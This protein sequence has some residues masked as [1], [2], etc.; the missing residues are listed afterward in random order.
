[1]RTRSIA[2]DG[3]LGCWLTLVVLLLSWGVMAAGGPDVGTGGSA[4]PPAVGRDGRLLRLEGAWPV[5]QDWT[6][7]SDGAG[8]YPPALELREPFESPTGAGFTATYEFAAPAA[9]SYTLWLVGTPP[10]EDWV[11]PL[12]LTLNGQKL[13]FASYR[14]CGDGPFSWV[15]LTDVELVRGDNLLSAQVI[16]RR[17]FPDNE[18]CFYLDEL[19]FAPP[20][21]TPPVSQPP[22]LPP[23]LN[24]PQRTEL[25][26][27]IDLA[28]KIRP[29]PPVPCSLAQGAGFSAWPKSFLTA[30]TPE[31][32]ALHPRYVRK[33]NF[34]PACTKTATGWTYDFTECDRVV[35][36]IL[37]WGAT[38]ILCLEL[39]GPAAT[40]VINDQVNR[41]GLEAYGYELARHLR[42]TFAGKV[43]QWEFLNE[44]DQR[45]F[46]KRHYVAMFK[47]I[48][49][50][51][52]RGDPQAQVGGPATVGPDGV[53][54]FAAQCRAAGVRPDFVSYHTYGVAGQAFVQQAEDIRGQARRIFN[55]P[56]LPLFVTEWG[57]SSTCSPYWWNSCAAAF[58]ASVYVAMA[59]RAS[60]PDL[61]TQ[62]MIKD[63]AGGG[64]NFGLFTHTDQPYPSYH[65][66]RLFWSMQGEM[67]EMKGNASEQLDGI[68]VANDTAITV[69]L[70][71]F[72]AAGS[73]RRTVLLNLA[74]LPPGFTQY[75]LAV[76]DPYNT[77]PYERRHTVPEVRDLA[78]TALRPL[79]PGVTPQL[80]VEMVPPG[81]T[82]VQLERKKVSP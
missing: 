35:R 78:W 6:R 29:F 62:F 81:V 40:P 52:H 42:L 74:H 36:E 56:R 15:R 39:A 71:Y 28:K 49:A 82:V 2:T 44:P 45:G 70:Y 63:L 21:W 13:R 53:L 54:P 23:P 17:K 9:G 80:P 79:P 60:A 24:R 51:I 32:M 12:V 37:A 7:A 19:I 31:I 61:A 5:K 55:Q 25:A 8:Q 34:A 16:E 50:G 33:D 69:Y 14:A 27:A 26:F 3:W 41:E 4:P 47:A 68:A 66:A 43:N 72:A 10:R 46:Y 64:A 48:A 77:N 73:P 11:S 20:G 58:N 1:M 22:V 30:I 65:A 18:F 75:R 57:V 38:P 59:K 76:I 67:V